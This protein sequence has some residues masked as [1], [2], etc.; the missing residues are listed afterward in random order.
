MTFLSPLYAV[1]LAGT[2]VL[3]WGIR[4]RPWRLWLLLVASLMFYASLQLQ[5][6]PLLIF[7]TIVNFYL[8]IAIGTTTDPRPHNKN[9]ELSN[10]EWTIAQQKW[11]QKRRFILAGGIIFNV[12][13]LLGFK[14]GEFFFPSVS[15][16][17]PPSQAQ[18]YTTWLS[19]YWV[20]PLGVSFF[21]FECI[22]YLVDVY[23]GAPPSRQLLQFAS[24]KFFFAKL[25]AGPIT[26]FHYWIEKFDD[27]PPLAP[28]RVTEGLWLIAIGAIKK[29]LVADNL[30]I[31]VDLC[32][33]NLQRAGS[34]DLWLATI[35]YGF[36][37]YLDFS[38]YVD[39]ARGTAKLLGLSLPPN[40]DFPYL[41]PSLADFWRRWHMT[42]GD[43]LRNYLYF[44]LGGSRQ[45]LKRTCTNL[46]IVMVVAGI[47]HGGASDRHDPAGYLIWGILHGLGLV[48]HRLTESAS[49]DNSLLE[50]F[51]KTI[52]GIGLSWLLTQTLVFG[53]WI[54][55]RLPSLT[56]SMWVVTHLWGYP[57]DIQ[58][59]RE[60]YVETLQIGRFQI[61][62]AL[63]ILAALMAIAYLFDR[64]FKVQLNWP[65]KVVLIP[66]CFYV[67]WLLAPETLP[68]IYFDF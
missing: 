12:A 5:S 3:Y 20:V 42:L 61:A 8:G 59:V 38:G 4:S 35:A 51:W 18:F 15:A 48:L 40:F 17:L 67:V 58:F 10:E 9:W 26:R 41:S 22:A 45:G 2:I 23:R 47:W 13:I 65:V 19:P 32:F 31:F 53:S 64:G 44:P 6:L 33:G 52:P 36:Q 39:M 54:F 56:D 62:I 25:I 34:P 37:L 43:W 11:Q 50:A 16:W 60:I 29:G 21:S 14:Y 63:G 57:G 1:F 28:D 49:R 24:Y 68:F 27:R 46:F 55:F 7:S 30:G 66:V